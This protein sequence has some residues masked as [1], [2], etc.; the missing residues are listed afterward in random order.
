MTGRAWIDLTRPDGEIA[1]VFV[2]AIA[3][4]EAPVGG[5]GAGRSRVLI[6]GEYRRFLETTQEVLAKLEALK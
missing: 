5:E 2:N 6:S 4:V 1:V 3:M